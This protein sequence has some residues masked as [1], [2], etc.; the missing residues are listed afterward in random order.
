VKV[1]ITD[2]NERA[3]LAVTRALGSE[4]VEVIVGAESQRSLAGSSRYCRQ[5]ISYPSPYQEPERFIATLMEAVR[6]HRVDVVIPLSDIAMHVL[7]PEKAQFERYTHFP[8]PSPQAFQE[9][10]DKYRLMQQALREGVA[11]PDTTFVPDGRVE[12]IAEG[13]VDFPVV[14]KPGCS[15]VRSGNQW[16]KTSV[17]YAESPDELLR[18]YRE[19]PYLR[20]PSLIQRR[21]IGEGQGLFVLMQEG[22]PLG[23]FAH[24]RVRERPPSGGVSVLRESIALPKSMVDATLKL[25]QGV[26]WH[27]VAMVEFKVDAATQRPLLME[28]NGRFW[29]SLQ[30]AID[31]GLNFPLHLL[32]MAMGR[33][34]TIPENGYR[35]GVKSRWL[36]GDLD[37]LVMRIRN[38]DRALNLPPGAPSRFQALMS[39]CRF[40]E[41]DTFYEVERIDDLGPSRFE[42]M[43]YLKLV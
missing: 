27:G 12:G 6:T 35:V 37:Q 36:L 41:R 4:Q 32:N 1:L 42:V 19:R 25:L 26:K 18:L 13:I 22:T 29:G 15:L 11:I 2:G 34:E 17:C 39:F 30:L 5:S 8:A 16:T 40:F 24:R 23:M 28:I 33:G 20:Q 14:V 38:G 21:V 10:S 9:I 31:A 3:A 43:R 7:G